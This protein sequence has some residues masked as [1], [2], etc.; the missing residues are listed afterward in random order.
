M[1][2]AVCVPPSAAAVPRYAWEA[3]VINELADLDLFLSAPGVSLSLP[4]KGGVFLQIIGVRQE[5]FMVDVAV[6]V[7]MYVAACGFVVGV[8]CWKNRQHRD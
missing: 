6:L 2:A 4:M 1:C 5:L 8:V 3:L 7:A